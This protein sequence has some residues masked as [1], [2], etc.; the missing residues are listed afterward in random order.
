MTYF[1]TG[2]LYSLTISHSF[3]LPILHCLFQATTNLF[4][5]P[6]SLFL[7]Y[8]VYKWDH[9]VF[10]FFCL[11]FHLAKYPLDPPM[12]LECCQ[13]WQYFLLF[14]CLNSIQLYMCATSS[15]SFHLV[16]DTGCFHILAI[17]ITSFQISGFV[18]FG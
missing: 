14:L 6:M 17:V 8:L 16:I 4:S 15:L 7:S 2:S 3:I 13:K 11:T 12:D 1:I 9:I 10:V 18:F 5:V